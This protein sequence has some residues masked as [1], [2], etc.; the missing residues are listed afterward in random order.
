[1][2]LGED[3]KLR[4]D[5]YD[6]NEKEATLPIE[7]LTTPYKGVVYRYTRVGI[8]ENEAQD[9]AV[10]Q[11]DYDF[12]DPGPFTMVKLRSDKYFNT[13]IGLVLN[14]ILLDHLEGEA[15]ESENRGHD[16]KES[17]SQ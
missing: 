10:M 14:E 1:M 15:N 12:V 6:P 13:T 4:D 7:L 17:D 3:F 11:F 2:K 9:G 8:K 16:S 5:L